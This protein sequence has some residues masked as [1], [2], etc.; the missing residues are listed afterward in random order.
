MINVCSGIPVGFG[1][2]PL[3]LRWRTT[4]SPVKGDVFSDTHPVLRGRRNLCMVDGVGRSFVY[5]SHSKS[6]SWE[7]KDAVTRITDVIRRGGSLVMC[8]GTDGTVSPSVG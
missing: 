2:S 8:R 6:L 1:F 7:G 4:P 3:D 5:I